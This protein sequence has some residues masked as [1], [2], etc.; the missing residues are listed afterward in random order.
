MLLN[1]HIFIF[2]AGGGCVVFQFLAKNVFG[3]WASWIG[4]MS[5]LQIHSKY[6]L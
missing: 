5:P 3:K 6:T 4:T 2:L 1:S